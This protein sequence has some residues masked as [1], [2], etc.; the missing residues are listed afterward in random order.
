[1]ARPRGVRN[2]DFA[3]T[4]LELLGRLTQQ[5]LVDR[6]RLESF[7]E[8][9]KAAGV[10]RT[11]LRHYFTDKPGVVAA[12]IQ[13]WA[14]FEPPAERRPASGAREQLE[15]ALMQLVDGWGRGLGDFFELGLQ[16]AI[17]DRAVGPAFVTHF[18]EP[19]LQGFEVQLG[20]L[21]RAGLLEPGDTRFAAIELV[22]PVVMALMHQR[23]LSGATCRPLDVDAFTRAH[24]K[25][26]VETRR[27]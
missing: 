20:D 13:Y 6:S 1:V 23:S 17:G 4:R 16:P 15:V 8:L 22:S 19:L 27:P 10:S 11:T 9:A 21:A 5:V 26:F 3:Q 14:S 2:R 18:L 12:L 25:R 24:V 7:N